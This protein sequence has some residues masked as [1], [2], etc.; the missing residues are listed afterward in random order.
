MPQIH[1]KSIR[2]AAALLAVVLAGVALS[3]C[4]GS[5]SSSSST[6]NAAGASTS[7]DASATATS[8]ASSGSS[9]SAATPGARAGRFGAFRECLKKNGIAPPQR[10]P[11]QRGAPF[12]GGPQLPAGISR[13][14]YEAAVKKCGGLPRGRFFGAKSALRS[15]AATQAFKEFA[16]CM[17][18]HGVKLPEPNTSGKGPIFASKGLN[19]SSASF[20]AAETACRRVL[21]GAFRA[22]PGARPGAGAPSAS[23]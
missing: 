17:R 7:A 4:G 18:E 8:G 21:L 3:A 9:G 1:S 5:S 16:S 6:A 10:K 19:T 15:A 14:R 20:K 13:G 22:R 2:A 12:A 11:G 23:G